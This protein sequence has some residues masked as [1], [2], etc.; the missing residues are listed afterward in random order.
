MGPEHAVEAARALQAA[1]FVPIHYNRTFE[2]PKYYR[3]LA[4]ARDR[5]DSLAA[6]RDVR[7]AHL[8]PGRWVDGLAQ[9]GTTQVAEQS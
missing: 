5:I 4:D 8:E 3:P 9:L 6:A 2:H 7:V 1:A